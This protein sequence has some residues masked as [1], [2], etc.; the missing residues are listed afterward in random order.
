MSCL[1]TLDL[2]RNDLADLPLGIGGMINLRDVDFSTNQLVTMPE[3]IGALTSLTKL[4]LME[5]K[6]KTT[7]GYRLAHL[8]DGS[9]AA[10]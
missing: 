7:A 6:L 5:N 8:C 2:S 10:G 3:T 4:N 1:R 9:D